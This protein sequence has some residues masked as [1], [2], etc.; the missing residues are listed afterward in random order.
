MEEIVGESLNMIV[1]REII[2]WTKS[3]EERAKDLEKVGV[4]SRKV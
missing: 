4:F 1:V 2:F 3:I